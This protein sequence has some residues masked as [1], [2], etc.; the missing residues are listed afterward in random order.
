MTGSSSQRWLISVAFM[1]L[2]LLPGVAQVLGVRTEASSSEHRRLAQRPPFPA[3][4]DELAAFPRRFERYY[5]DHFG[6]RDWMTWMYS[7]ALFY[8][9]KVVPFRKVRIR[10]DGWIFENVPGKSGCRGYMKSP[11]EIESLARRRFGYWK[12]LQKHGI[13]YYLFLVPPKVAVYLPTAPQFS[14]A[15]EETN[16]YRL[17]QALR[18]LSPAFPVIDSFPHLVRRKREYRM[19][20]LSDPHWTDL[21]AYFSYRALMEAIG[22]HHP[23]VKPRRLEEFEIVERTHTPG[24]YS[25][26]ANLSLDETTELFLVP[27][28]KARAVCTQGVPPPKTLW[29]YGSKVAIYRVEGASLPKALIFRDSF[30]KRLTPWMIEHFSEAQLLWSSFD[31][32]RAIKAKPDIV[33]HQESD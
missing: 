16:T 29:R 5:N 21:G 22:E 23:I 31:L 24:A 33:I 10:S 32:E 13:S 11:E 6:L 9:L 7:N 18:K 17:A 20:F 27:R 1:A 12:E 15:K 2:I 14:C 4:L 25:R 8:G 3:D 30:F 28:F 19:Y 26:F